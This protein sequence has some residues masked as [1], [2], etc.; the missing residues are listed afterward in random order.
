MAATTQPLVWSFFRQVSGAEDLGA[1]VEY[2]TEETQSLYLAD[3]LKTRTAQI[4]EGHWSD[5][6]PGAEIT[7]SADDFT[8]A[9]WDH[10]DPTQLYASAILGGELLFL[11]YHSSMDITDFVRSGSC[12]LRDDSQIKQVSLR[13]ANL[14]ADIFDAPY[15][16]FE[17]GAKITVAWTMG[18]SDPYD[19]AAAYLD[20]FDFDRLAAE[21]SMSGRSVTARLND[22]T[23]GNDTEFE[24]YGNEVVAWILGL[25]GIDKYHIGPSDFSQEWT[26]APDQ[27]LLKGLQ[28]VFDFFPGWSMIELP[29]GTICVAYPHQLAEWQ[30]NSVYQFN[31]GSE[32]IKRKTKKQL[33]AAF[34]AVRVT[35]K[36]ADGTELTPVSVSVNNFAGWNLGAHKIRH[37]K[38]ADGLTQAE[39][40]ALAEQLAAELQHIGVSETFDAPPRPWLLPGDIASISYG[41][42][43][44]TDL[45]LVTS[46]SHTFGFSGFFTQFT[47]DSGGVATAQTRAGTDYAT[48][49]AAVNGYNRS[50]SLA[51]LVIA[52]A[53]KT[54]S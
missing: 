5:A 37:V 19:I 1:V 29:D 3:G 18:D 49:T 51:D 46:I 52:L 24:G 15:S 14:G 26:F 23:F 13:I 38:A 28:D 4:S 44:S 35:G 53:Q 47:V 7:V 27:T 33:D 34:T 41:G 40:Q 32:V 6:T 10:P 2:S 12:K 22:Q 45:G 8:A 48:R 17:P 25:A 54:K 20:E 21:A 9:G 31:G 11:R 43:V 36:A 39:L 42:G 50:Q 30:Q 16:L